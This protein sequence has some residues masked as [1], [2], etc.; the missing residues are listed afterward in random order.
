MPDALRARGAVF[1]VALR[2]AARV[3]KGFVV[4]TG[5]TSDE[6]GHANERDVD[7]WLPVE[8]SGRAVEEWTGYTDWNE[9]DPPLEADLPSRWTRARRRFRGALDEEARAGTGFVLATVPFGLGIIAYFLA[10]IEPDGLTAL[11]LAVGFLAAALQ[12]SLRASPVFIAVALV[13]A[14]FAVSKARTSAL[15]T[16][17]VPYPSVGQLTG[18]V[19]WTERRAG[20]GVRYTIEVERFE[21]RDGIELQRVR[22]VHRKPRTVMRPGE[23]IA[24]RVRLLPSSGPVVPGGYD[25]A[26]Y[27]WFAGRSAIGSVLGRV[28]AL[29]VG[30]RSFETTIASWRF[31]IGERLGAG[32]P[33]ETGPLA[34]A[35]VIGDRSGIEEEVA[36]DLR[37]SG[38][39]HILA[40]SGL[41]MA[42]VTGLVFV[43]IRKAFALASSEAQRWPVKRWAAVGALLFATVY[44]LLS[45]MN[46]STQRA[47][48]MVCIMLF[49]VLLDRQAVTLRNVAIAAFAVLAWQ[50]E[51]I[52]SPGFQMSFAAAASLVACYG[53]LLRWRE[54]KAKERN[55]VGWFRSAAVWIGGLSLTSL[56]AGFATAPFA[57]FHFH[58]IALLSLA[59]NLLAMPVVTFLVMPLTVIAVLLMPLGLDPV[60]LPLLAFALDLVGWIAQFVAGYG[61]VAHTGIVPGATFAL[62]VLGMCALVMLRTKLRLVGLVPCALAW[63]PLGSATPLAVINENARNV[64]V[65]EEDRLRHSVGRLGS[66][67]NKL[68]A[69]SFPREGEAGAFRS[70]PA[71]S[72]ARLPDG[73]IIAVSKNARSLWDDCRLAA[74]IVA[75]FRSSCP[76]ASSAMIVDGPTLRRRGAAILEAGPA[77]YALRHAYGAAPRPWTRHR[78]R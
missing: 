64:S 25:F 71:G 65:I 18:T 2:Q 39:A 55:D 54:R 68:V 37:L 70:D 15:D 46:V 67:V 35:L 1:R 58:R 33:A 5:S 48:V 28:E 34:R 27:D 32:M 60:I 66:F 77:G 17:I 51:A 74:V 22:V 10:P 13:I 52:F 19:V 44:L 21:G 69:E 41:H 14:G 7:A 49:A 61:W 75:R 6:A 56:V 50:P 73:R 76:E 53:A 8:P 23:R 40:I 42:L 63:L 9:D 26:F 4:G 24:A 30:A 16:T 11:L 57:A 47:Y 59:G 3:G 72:A 78:Y 62:S 31:A 20:G 12:P 45:G 38:L 29:G 43:T 36:E